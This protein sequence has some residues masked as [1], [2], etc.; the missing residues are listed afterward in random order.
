MA[1]RLRST[2]GRTE[3]QRHTAAGS[4]AAS[5]PPLSCAVPMQS[6]H[7]AAWKQNATSPSLDTGGNCTSAG[8]MAASAEYTHRSEAP[9]R[10][11]KGK[12]RDCVIFRPFFASLCALR[13]ALQLF[14]SST[15]SP[16]LSRPFQREAISARLE[17]VPAQDELD[18]AERGGLSADLR[19][20]RNN[21]SYK[22]NAVSHRQRGLL[23]RLLP[24]LKIPRLLPLQL[25]VCALCGHKSAFSR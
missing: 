21:N 3:L 11:L 6:S 4:P 5:H 1:G 13:H 25:L 20:V 7:D 2:G 16:L 19:G 17:E 24:R 18:A 8:A 12:R 10:P 15:T 22:G 9:S 14:F 23:G